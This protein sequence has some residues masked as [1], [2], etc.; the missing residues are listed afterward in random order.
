VLA[1]MAPAWLT[2]IFFAALHAVYAITP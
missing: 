2:R 1:Q